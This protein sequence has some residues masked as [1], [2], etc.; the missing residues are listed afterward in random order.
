MSVPSAGRREPPAGR[1]RWWARPELVLALVVLGLGVLVI[2]GTLDV[3]ASASAL[4][5]GPRFF[6]LLVGGAM[7]LIGLFY[8]ADV[9]RGGH[10][11]P[12]ETEDVDAGAPADWRSVLLVSGIFLAF[13]AILPL[14][15][16][17]I[18]AS[19][20]FFALAV[21]LG[22]EHKLRAAL[23]GVVLGVTTYLVFVK[24]L[25]VTLPGGPF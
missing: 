9:L 1:T 19:L 16:W 20:L 7:V 18:A 17:M 14:A 22:A 23:I 5:L 21:A 13:V 15:G 3:T 4:G 10:G 25:G 2:L 6:P 8:V 12:E 24:G 11:D